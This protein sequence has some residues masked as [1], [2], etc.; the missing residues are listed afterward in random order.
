MK[1]LFIPD[2]SKSNPYQKLLEDCLREKKVN[3][4]FTKED[5]KRIF[6]ISRSRAISTFNG[7]GLLHIHWI[8]D[9]IETGTKRKFLAFFKV[10]NFILDI[11]MVKKILNT[12]I[13]WTVHNLQSHE[14]KHP[15]IEL[16]AR[17]Y[18]AK[19]VDALICHSETAKKMISKTYRVSP[20]KI[21]VI[22]H[23]NYI[24]CYEN[25]ISKD[26]SRKKLALAKDE[27]V[28]LYF[29]KIKPYKGVIELVKV[30][31]E[32]NT[33]QTRKIKLLIVGKPQ[34]DQIKCSIISNINDNPNIKTVFN[35]IPDNKIQ[36]YMNA[37]DVV[38]LPYT[39][40]LMSGAA[41]LAIS[42]GKPI[43][44]PMMGSIPDILDEKGAFLYTS[45][46]NNGLLR[47]IKQAINSKGRL[48]EMGNYNLEVAKKLDWNEIAEK[49]KKL[50]EICVKKYEVISENR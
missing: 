9:Y 41:I 31:N 12:K 24:N 20:S 13:V 35:L 45:D 38:V 46:E 43:I 32:L 39:D 48:E 40:I 34:N 5:T 2:Y 4:C 33:A 3:A 21:H 7:I 37:A 36:I 27:I 28:F 50:Y 25:K 14:C 44:A 18:L 10:L 47:A 19:K 8:S 16:L 6:P 30:F 17:K 1:V 26:D 23:G 49:T 15:Q 11:Y 29:G 22:P 42:F